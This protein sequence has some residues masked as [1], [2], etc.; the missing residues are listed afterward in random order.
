MS[1]LRD[2]ERSATARQVDLDALDIRELVRLAK[3]LLGTLKRYQRHAAATRFRVSI[4][5]ILAWQLFSRTAVSAEA[6]LSRLGLPF[7]CPLTEGSHG[8]LMAVGGLREWLLR[9]RGSDEQGWAA[10]QQGP[11][12]HQGELP[13]L[14]L[15]LAELREVVRDLSA[16]APPDEPGGTTLGQAESATSIR[17]VAKRKAGRP[18]K[19]E[20]D[21]GY[22]V[23]G[24]LIKHHRY[25]P[26]G[27][28]ENYEPATTRDLAKLASGERVKVSV[29]TVSRLFKKKFPGRGYKG[30]VNAC[31]RDA[32]VNIGMF[33]ALWQ[34][35]VAE[36]Y[37]DLL[38]HESGHE[39]RD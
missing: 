24:A 17:P 21:K 38:P 32:K 26:G 9:M 20:S 35:D 7:R 16:A 23:I 8:R 25:Q 18:G 29:A 28:V 1:Q 31:N 27:I 13:D 34:G 5:V 2:A 39:A 36:R 30:Y 14:A 33:L 4:P 15:P 10:R 37:A 3:G 19:G 12:I 11:P 6:E 22:L